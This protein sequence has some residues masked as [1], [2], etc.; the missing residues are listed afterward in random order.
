[1]FIVLAPRNSPTPV[2]LRRMWVLC[3]EKGLHW[4]HN[5]ESE[6]EIELFLNEQEMSF[7]FI[8][9]NWVICDLFL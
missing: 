3:N 4:S 5:W 6:H 7:I 9:S 8:S 1:M 2:I